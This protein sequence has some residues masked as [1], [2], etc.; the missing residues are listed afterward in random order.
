MNQTRLALALG[1]VAM[2]PTMFRAD[3][4][5]W[6][7]ENFHVFEYFEQSANKVWD[8]G[9]KHYSA[10]TIVEVMRHRTNIREIGDGTWKLNDKRT[11]DMSR[12]FS[13]LHP[14]KEGLFELRRRTA[15]GR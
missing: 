12:L 14:E 9:F 8:S 10:R 4:Y 1:E 6:L 3:F 11:P 7:Q 15:N 2:N 5:E 13:L